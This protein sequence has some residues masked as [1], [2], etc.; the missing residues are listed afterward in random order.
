MKFIVATIIIFGVVF[1][2][3]LYGIIKTVSE[4]DRAE[5]ERMRRAF[6]DKTKD[7]TEEITEGTDADS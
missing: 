6:Y 3:T 1:F 4:Y 5:E 7:N 2:A